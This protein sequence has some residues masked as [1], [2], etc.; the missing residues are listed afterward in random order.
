MWN[1]FHESTRSKSR[2]QFFGSLWIVSI[3]P[4]A[5]QQAKNP[6]TCLIPIHVAA[7]V[8]HSIHCTIVRLGWGKEG[9]YSWQST[10]DIL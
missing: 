10:L 4:L 3:V 8:D 6:L 1:S 2:M 9:E 5:G 7:P